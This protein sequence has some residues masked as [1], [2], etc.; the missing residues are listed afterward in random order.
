[1]DSP[2]QCTREFIRSGIPYRHSVPGSYGSEDTDL[3]VPV[4]RART[5]QHT[6]RRLPNK[7]ATNFSTGQ[8]PRILDDEMIL[9]FP[10][11]GASHVE[12][13]GEA[14]FT[15]GLEFF[16]VDEPI[17]VCIQLLQKF[18]ASMYRPELF[19]RTFP[20]HLLRLVQLIAYTMR[21]SSVY[22]VK[23]TWSSPYG[24]STGVRQ[25]A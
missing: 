8:K 11:A 15:P 1:L 17:M 14:C 18:S 2:L 3:R 16:S 9:V 22:S 21:V 7:Q 5:L 10:C 23:V 25:K 19:L 6:F 12:F 24:G 4:P 20:P 13:Q